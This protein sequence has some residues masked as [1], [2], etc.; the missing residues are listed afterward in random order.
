M[1]RKKLM[2][3][4]VLQIAVVLLA[5]GL[6]LHFYLQ[7]ELDKELSAKLTAIASM[8]SVQ[9][10]AS[11][12]SLLGPGDENTRTFSNMSGRLLE[13]AEQTDMKR[14]VVI[15]PAGGI[16]LDSHFKN[17]IGTIYT[18]FQMFSGELQATLKGKNASSP[19]FRGADGQ[20]YKS[21]FAPLSQNGKVFGSIVVEGSAETLRTVRKIRSHLLQIGA[22]S[23]AGSLLLAWLVANRLTA[24][25]LRLQQACKR[26]GLGQMKEPITVSGR[27]EI[28]FL[29]GTI[30]DMRRAILH[31]DE[32]QKA[33]LAGVAHEI[34]NPLGGIELFAGLLHDDLTDV[35]KKHK[36]E[37]ILRETRNLKELIQNFL[38]YARPV[39]PKR[40]LCEINKCW[41]ETEM[42]ISDRLKKKHI[43]S[44][45]TGTGTAIADPQHVKQILLNL[46][47]NAIEAMPEG[48]LITISTGTKDKMVFIRFQNNGPEIPADKRQKI[49]EPFFSDKEKGL[50]L[51]LTMVK[52]LVEENGGQI[53][54]E[55][56]KKHTTFSILLPV[57]V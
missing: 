26:I 55:S 9:M 35:E 45:F 7:T 19:L 52:T 10:D 11:L 14:I 43:K 47:L 25:L 53:T 3:L 49:F 44:T 16:W 13:L 4:F 8:V 27:D 20:W 23:F 12:I 37:K 32:R 39:L 41:Q 18:Y 54:L 30:E 38:D 40:D 17:P 2:L 48:G 29:A 46:A 28:A 56:N 15:T 1:I 51:G 21:G 57:P 5:S 6:Y 33:M 36:A 50:G 42:L 24:P 34:R 31:R 22:V